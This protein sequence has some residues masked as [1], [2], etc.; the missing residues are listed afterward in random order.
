MPDDLQTYVMNAM[1]SYIYTL[2]KKK[3]FGEIEEYIEKAS[4]AYRMISEVLTS[5]AWGWTPDTVDILE[6]DVTYYVS[7]GD[8]FF[9]C[10]YY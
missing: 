4:D 1:E 6:H 8:D 10:R 9:T 2:Y 5:A 3:S 7:Y